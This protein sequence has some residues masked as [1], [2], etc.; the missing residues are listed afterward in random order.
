MSNVTR[1]DDLSSSDRQ[2]QCSVRQ[3]ALVILDELDRDSG[4]PKHKRPLPS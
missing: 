2:Y 3:C 4:L 1:E